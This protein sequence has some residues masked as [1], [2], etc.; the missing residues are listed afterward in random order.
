ME[1]APTRPAFSLSA[2]GPLANFLRVL[3]VDD[4]RDYAD[5]SATLLEF[6]G[7]EAFVAYDGL[8]ALELART[9]RPDVALLDLAVNGMDGFTI[10]ERL[11]RQPE[12]LDVVL[13][14]VTG[15]GELEARQRSA[16]SGFLHH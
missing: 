9:H 7:H 4:D 3:I 6:W 2:R 8:A 10:A 13:I 14:A 16:A 15:R 5:S 11:R 12:S 1:P